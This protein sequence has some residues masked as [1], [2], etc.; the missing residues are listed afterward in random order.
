MPLRVWN[1]P[2]MVDLSATFAPIDIVNDAYTT[3]LTMPLYHAF[4]NF[5]NQRQSLLSGRAIVRLEEY[6]ALPPGDNPDGPLVAMRFLEM[7]TPVKRLSNDDRVQLP[8]EGQLLTRRG[9]TG[10]YAPWGYNPRN[11]RKFWIDWIARSRMWVQD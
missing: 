4:R 8:L 6:P 10:V 7:F 2:F 9:R 1:D 3:A 11:N 5:S